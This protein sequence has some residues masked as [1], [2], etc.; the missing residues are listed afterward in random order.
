MLSGGGSCKNDQTPLSSPLLYLD[1]T[2]IHYTPPDIVHL[3]FTL[4][5]LLTFPCTDS[6]LSAG[7]LVTLTIGKQDFY[8]EMESI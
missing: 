1:A 7:Y 8:E 3:P 6:F 2:D 4:F 5:Y